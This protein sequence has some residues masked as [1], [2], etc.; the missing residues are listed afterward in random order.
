M[1][2]IKDPNCEEVRSVMKENKEIEEAVVEVIKLSE[3]EK[4]RKLAE[5]REKAI[6]DEKDI[7]RAGEDKGMKE[8]IKEGIKEGERKKTIE[9]AKE[10]LN[11][12][13]SIEQIIQATGLEKEK[14]EEIR[15][16]NG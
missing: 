11:M 1:M 12:N 10:L 13:L 4:M 2:F 5:L 14:I 6:M 16:R 8:G 7:F 15:K 3:D 9:I